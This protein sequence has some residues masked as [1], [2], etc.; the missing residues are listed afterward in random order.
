MKMAVLLLFSAFGLCFGSVYYVDS[1][2]GNDA[3]AG[4]T[5][6]EAWRTLSRV[7]EAE[8]LPGDSVLFR[9]GGVFRG[10]LI[11]VSGSEAGDVVYGAYGSGAKPRLLG[12][13]SKSA[14]SD[15]L[16]ESPDIWT[17]QAD[18]AAAIGP[19]FLPN[20]DFDSGLSNWY[21]WNN[22]A[23]GASSSLS[24]STDPGDYYT[25][26]AGGRLSCSAHGGGSSDIQLWTANLSIANEQWYRFSFKAKATRAFTIPF[27]GIQL[28]RTDPPYTLYSSSSSKP[29]VIT[30]S[31]TSHDVF[32]E[33][34]ATA[35]D[36]RID[37][38][39]GGLIPEAAILYFDSLSFREMDGD[40]G[41]IPC[42]VGNVIFDGGSSCGVKVWEDADLNAPGEFRY[43]PEKAVLKLVS[44][45]NPASVHSEV[46]CALTRHIISEDRKSYVTYEALDLRY[47]GAHGIGGGDTHHITVKEMDISW[48]GGGVLEDR[49]R[50][51]NGVEFWHS[52]HDNTVE[53]CTFDQVYDAACTVQ[54]SGD[55]FEA[56][57]I[58]F[59]NNVIRNSEYSFELWAEP[60]GTWLH[61]IYFEN[62]TCLNAGFGWGHS[63]RPDPNGGHLMLW[64]NTNE[65]MDRVCIRNNIFSESTHY[66]VRCTNR[67]AVS[68]FTV[69]YNC[70]W[71]SSGPVAR[72]EN[73]D[74]DFASGWD[75]Y[76]SVS[77][78]DGHSIHADPLLN[79]DHSLSGE[80]PCM[81][82]GSAAVSVSD[83]FNGNPRPKAGGMDIGAFEY[84]DGSSGVGHRTDRSASGRYRLFPNPGRS[85][86]TIN[87]ARQDRPVRVTVFDVLGRQAGRAVV[88]AGGGVME[89]GDLPNGLYF[90]RLE[91]G[92]GIEIVKWVKY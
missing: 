11:P 37:F 72:I 92:A 63:Q 10:Q 61:D 3:A 40:P 39:L 34:G 42:D 81:D 18:R 83:D 26:P 9:R 75:E 87:P 8:L 79:P 12:S 44:V 36:A 47:G 57:D 17:T 62:N 78:Q 85:F 2:N 68:K 70:W 71:E 56:R 53:R 74:Y 31:W 46:E 58:R 33:S 19:E 82:A 54:G 49:V 89:T 67:S 60:A 77:G 45:P 41:L 16:L 52:A 38:F 64:G 80:S 35:A 88:R 15:W 48:I 59:R 20:P 43:D 51:G 21:L 76:R 69:D 30:E 50:Y 84:D 1:S 32:F 73:T 5:P 13:V 66:G 91:D 90:L 65:R 14:V 27:G 4:R 24:R 25:A 6:S 29:A 7:N 55:P 28:M 23:S 22:S 86:V